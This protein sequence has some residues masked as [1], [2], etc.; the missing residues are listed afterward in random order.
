VLVGMGVTELSVRPSAVPAIKAQLR[1][2]SGA[3]ARALAEEVA[4]LP[5]AAA[6]AERIARAREIETGID[7]REARHSR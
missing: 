7:V 6:V 2:L 5:T 3:A 1:R 4:A